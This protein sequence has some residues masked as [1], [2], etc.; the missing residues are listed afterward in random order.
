MV[1]SLYEINS[2]CEKYQN[3]VKCF[4]PLNT[5]VKQ[6]YKFSPDIFKIFINDLLELLVNENKPCYNL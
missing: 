3:Q 2:S 6:G 4:S 5:G 1:N